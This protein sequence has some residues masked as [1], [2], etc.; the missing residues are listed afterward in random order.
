VGEATTDFFQALGARGHEPALENVTGTIRFDVRDGGKVIGR[1]TISIRKGD[2]DVSRRNA[3]ADC[4][5]RL[6]QTLLDGIAS[7]A[8]NGMAALVRGAVDVEGDAG[9]LLAFQRLFPGPPRGGS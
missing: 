9:L 4:V 2:V 8:T 7:G 5:V 6:D 3:K 1:W